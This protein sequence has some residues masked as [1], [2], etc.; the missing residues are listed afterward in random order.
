MIE[1]EIRMYTFNPICIA[2]CVLNDDVLMTTDRYFT[3]S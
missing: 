3:F 1:Y 2:E